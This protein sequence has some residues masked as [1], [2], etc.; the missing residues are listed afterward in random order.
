MD[1]LPRVS[2]EKSGTFMNTATANTIGALA[3]VRSAVGLAADNPAD[4]PDLSLQEFLP[5]EITSANKKPQPISQTAAAVF[6]ITQE[7]IRHSGVTSIPE[8]LRMAPLPKLELAFVGF[9]L[10]DDRHPEF[11]SEYNDI[12]QVEIRRSIFDQ[13]RLEFE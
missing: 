12:P 6:V 13:V 9:E 11:I 2:A 5:V 1:S 10:L 4:C 8:A 7:D 3:I